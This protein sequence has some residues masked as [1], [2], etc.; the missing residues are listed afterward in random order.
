MQEAGTIRYVTT[1]LRLLILFLTSL[2]S[3]V[4]FHYLNLNDK[5]TASPRTDGPALY[6]SKCAICH[7]KDG[8]GTPSWR[9]KGQ[10]DFSNAEWQKSV[11][12]EQLAASIKDGKGKMP[13]F[14]SRLTEEEIKSLVTQV[15]AFK[16]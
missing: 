12:D 15:R 8:V 13:S 16:R 5:V 11:S 10:P 14:A 6:G 9:A 3:V 2:T 4:V 7:A 1:S